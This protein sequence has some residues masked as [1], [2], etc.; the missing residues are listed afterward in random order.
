MELIRAFPKVNDQF[1]Q[2]DFLF[3]G[4]EKKKEK[5]TYVSDI[6][7]IAEI[8]TLYLNET[9]DIKLIAFTKKLTGLEGIDKMIKTPEKAYKHR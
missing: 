7:L 6:N 9:I 3:P 2:Y 8:A 5:V 1:L 4:C